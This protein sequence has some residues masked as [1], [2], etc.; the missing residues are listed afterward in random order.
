GGTDLHVERAPGAPGLDDVAA[1]AL[2]AR[3][4]VEGMDVGLHGFV[5]RTLPRE[6]VPG[7]PAGEGAGLYQPPPP[8][9]RARRYRGHLVFFLVADADFLRSAR[10]FAA[11]FASGD[12][13]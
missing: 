10:R 9:A 3:G 13:G 7:G 11:A 1:G 4:R 2:D 12:F 8:G 6:G 5:G